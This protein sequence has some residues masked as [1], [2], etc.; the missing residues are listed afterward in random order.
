MRTG[1]SHSGRFVF[2]LLQNQLEEAR[3]C[4]SDCLE[5]SDADFEQEYQSAER[6]FEHAVAAYVDL[7]DTLRLATAERQEEP[8]VESKLGGRNDIN[9]KLKELRKELDQAK[10]RR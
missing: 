8:L 10:D 4:L 9:A 6:A 7:L 1:L 3:S 2:A 5:A